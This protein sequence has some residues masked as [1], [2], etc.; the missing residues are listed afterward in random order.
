MALPQTEVSE[1]PVKITNLFSS[2]EVQIYFTVIVLC[3]Q[4]QVT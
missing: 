4:A 3:I 2:L 1:T